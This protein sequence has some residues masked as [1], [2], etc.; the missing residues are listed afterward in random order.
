MLVLSD[1]SIVI[2]V[3]AYEAQEEGFPSAP[4]LGPF[5]TLVS[6]LV[7]FTVVPAEAWDVPIDLGAPGRPC[8]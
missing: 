4:A 3:R 7:L 8:V 6:M 2:S 5:V 1:R